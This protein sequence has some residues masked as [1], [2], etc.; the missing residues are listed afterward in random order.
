MTELLERAITAI[1]TLPTDA[2]DAIAARLLS[3]IEDEREWNIRFMATTDSQWDNLAN[4]V[5][6]SIANKKTRPLDE[7]FTVKEPNEI[8]CN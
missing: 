5:R 3:E 2:Q 6:T 1:K 4:R 8:E 7:I